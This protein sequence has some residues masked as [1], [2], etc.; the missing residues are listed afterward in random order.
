MRNINQKAWNLL[1]SDEKT[2]LNLQYGMNKSSW[3]AGEVMNK[4]HYKYLEIKYR[5]EAFL[6]LFTEHF[7][8]FEN[9]IPEGVTGSKEVIRY[10]DL[11]ITNR[12]KLNT[13]VHIIK[14]E[15]GQWLDR[16][17]QISEQ[18]KKWEKSENAYA[19]SLYHLI[20]EFDRWNNF[21]I[22]PPDIQEPSAFK[23]RNK[24]VHLKHIKITSTVPEISIPK[25]KK[26]LGKGSGSKVYLPLITN[27][28]NLYIISV[29]NTAPV[30]KQTTE[31]NLYIFKA[32]KEAEIYITLIKDYL[33]QEKK[34]CNDGLQFW[35][36]YRDAI[37]VA[38][39][40]EL[41]QKIVPSRRYLILALNKLEFY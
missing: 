11:V 39:N 15:F 14:E 38:I 32:Q 21:R 13:A 22:L 29:R 19:H 16:D 35:P 23:R 27:Q 25:I 41:I 2:A 26:I 7:K 9:I 34:T 8:Y 37:K 12:E 30:I 6:K 4:S 10:I 18:M 24:K 20:K 28:N 40:Y 1:L 3:E 31:L 5:A 17:T 36:K 33:Q